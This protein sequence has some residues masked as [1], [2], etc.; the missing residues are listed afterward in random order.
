MSKGKQAHSQNL[1]M[2]KHVLKLSSSDTVKVWWVPVLTRGKLH[3][4]PLPDNFP[5][6]T[7]E[8]AAVMV[9]RVRAA[10]NIRFQGGTAPKILFT[11]RGNGFYVS[12]TG[13]ITPGYDAA[14]KTHNLRAYFGNDAS[15][16]P[17]QLQEVMLHETAVSWMRLR[18][19][20]TVPSRSW[21][22]SVEAYRS[23]LKDCA[24]YINANYNIDSLCRE[25]PD[26][27]AELHKREGGRLAK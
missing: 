20:R 25:L 23:R 15:I 3:I 19:A 24:A 16:Q 14:L 17:G 11:D 21:E 26:R 5:G 13:R 1:R 2:P 12:G 4:E 6:E 8:G 27:V 22:E 18:L 9:T 7:E 10:L